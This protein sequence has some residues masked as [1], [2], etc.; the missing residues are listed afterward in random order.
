MRKNKQGKKLILGFLLLAGLV[1]LNLPLS[2]WAQEVKTDK[3]AVVKPVEAQQPV[4]D[5]K[6]LIPEAE[7]ELESVPAVETS[8]VTTESP[9]SDAAENVQSHAGRMTEQEMKADA[10]SQEKLGTD[11]HLTLPAE[12]DFPYA[13]IELEPGATPEDFVRKAWELSSQRKLDPLDKL[14]HVALTLFDTEA[15]KEEASLT[16]FPGRGKEK[17]YPYLNAVATMLFVQAEAMMNYGRTEQSIATFQKIIDEYPWAQAWDPS[18]GAYWSVAEKSQASIDVMTGKVEEDMEEP[19]TRLKTLPSPAF[20]G[21]EKVIDY[22]KYGEFVDVGTDHYHYKINDIKGLK[23]AVGEGIYPNTSDI[24]KDPKYI[25][26]KEEGRL[27]GSHWDFVHSDDLEAAFYKWA[28]A[29]EPE[30]IKLFYLALVLEKGKMYY[31]AVKA[32]H[33]IVVHFPKTVGWTYWQTPWSP[34]QAAVA[35][36]VHL[37]RSHPELNL[38]VKWMK[39]EVKN[40][41]DND[42]SNDIVIAYP[43]VIQEKSWIDKLKESLNLN[44]KKVPLRNIT[45]RLG[46]G[47]VSLVQYDNGHWQLMVEGKPYI[48]KGMT[49][50]PTKIGQSP[51]KGTLVSWMYEDTDKNGKQDGPYDTWVDAN[52]NNQQDPDEPVVGDFQLMK[53]MGVNTI[54]EY[55]QPF[56]PNKEVLRSLYNDYGIRVIMGDFFGKYTLGSGASWFEGT[57]YE[58]PEQQKNMM[59]SVRQM[60]LEH[61]DE[62]YLLLWLIGNENNYGVASNADKKPEAYY[63]FANEVAKMIK[64]IDPN[65][66]VALCNGDTL[67]LDIFAKNAPDIDMFAANVYRGDYG[68]GAF[69]QQIQESTGKAAFITE[70]GCPAYAKHLT[71]AEGEEAQANYHR[72]NWYDI[73][74]NMAGQAEGAGNALGGVV[75]EWTDEWWK[76]YEPFYHD[77][78]SDA[79]G[80]FPGG[81]YYEEWFGVTSQGNG[82][83]S[84]F[85]RQL[86]KSYEFYKQ[87]WN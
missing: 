17:D 4:D 7:A 14:L 82:T 28:T 3:P 1:Y 26:A 39:V 13:E 33:A 57:D 55:Q 51:D 35:K 43:G 52:G 5:E 72:G 85:M 59:D 36:L 30:G 19:P 87:V 12:G 65:H 31:E 2:G 60:V 64:S 34:A 50:A 48:I 53:E 71:R 70:Y 77:R 86:R 81:Y 15:R 66:P 67:Y 44:Q 40:G 32:Y 11:I 16:G 79:I 76:N 37:I 9:V 58:N 74:A 75:F 29:S 38:K 56:K 62:P 24:Y 41:F 20:P 68:F 69:W 10:A 8:A 84:P 22:Q 47:K 25:K 78:Q 61:K 73:E 83:H 21:T 54:R 42:V 27:E 46:E 80:P 45:R 49:Y 63:K 23:E 18:R 6:K